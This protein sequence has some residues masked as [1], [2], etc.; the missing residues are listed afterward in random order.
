MFTPV[1]NICLLSILLVANA[2]KAQNRPPVN[3]T[4][5]PNVP[6]LVTVLDTAE[7]K[8]ELASGNGFERT[9]ILADADISYIGSVSK[10]RQYVSEKLVICL[11]GTLVNGKGNGV[12]TSYV[13][14]SINHSRR[15]KISEQDYKNDTIDGH[16]KAF[17]IGG[18]LKYDLLYIKGRSRGKSV[19]YEAD[20]RTVKQTN[21]YRNDSVFIATT[22][23]DGIRKQEEQTLVNNVPNGPAK[24]YYPNGR[25][26]STVNFLNGQFNDTLKYYY[27]NGVLWTEEIF[28]KGRDWTVLNNFDKKGKPRPAGDLKDGY[29]TRILY[30][31]QGLVSDTV[32]YVNG[33]GTK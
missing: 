8:P 2:A 1:K 32:T 9:Y 33:I 3:S 10:K 14:D 18:T 12:F 17:D 20:G 6:H 15:Y 23:F 4:P 29:G 5:E 26:M 7:F 27:D 19:Y 28:K 30:T 25:I 11:E 21:Y 13:I 16:W 24:V 22:Y 31:E